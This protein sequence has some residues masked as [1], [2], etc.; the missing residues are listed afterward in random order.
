VPIDSVRRALGA[1]LL[2]GVLGSCGGGGAPIA[3][4][5]G[6]DRPAPATASSE[7]APSRPT[8][9]PAAT[10][11]GPPGDPPN[12]LGDV[13]VLMYHQVLPRP[14]GVYDITPRAFRAELE[15]LA[16]QGYV[17]VTAADYAAGRIDIPA[18]RHPVVLTFDDSTTSQLTLDGSDR[19]LAGTAVAILLDVAARHPGFT[20]TA[21]FYV[22]RD[23]FAEPGGRRTLGWLRDNGFEVGNHTLDHVALGSASAGRVRRQL[24]GDTAMIRRATAGAPVTTLALPFGVRP[25]PGRARR[26][27]MAGAW[28]GQRY[29]FDGAFL[30]GAGPAPSPFSRDFDVTG[31]PRIR[32]QGRRGPEAAYGSARWL[33]RLAADP[34][35]RYTSDGDPDS[36]ARPAG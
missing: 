28:G 8:T 18:G 34:A 22:N 31:I 7:P 35:R 21:T 4:S 20:P 32:S 29:A 23:P 5:G 30:V 26:L 24:A 17:P 16:R 25:S 2:C 11:T 27:M 19:P 1:L 12:A 6:R 36:V 10:P 15:R 14:R 3:S 13:P 33:D 9:A